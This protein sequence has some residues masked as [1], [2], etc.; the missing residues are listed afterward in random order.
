MKIGVEL[1]FDF[2]WL[3]FPFE[4]LLMVYTFGQLFVV[5]ITKLF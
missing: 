3:R 4:R 5:F 2:F 1:K